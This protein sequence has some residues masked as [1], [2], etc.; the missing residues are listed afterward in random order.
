MVTLLRSGRVAIEETTVA[1]GGFRFRARAA[2]PPDGELVMLLHGFPQSSACWTEALETLASAGYRAVAPDQR[3]YSPGARP[4]G[5]EGYRMSALVADAVRIAEA[6]G[7]RRF[8]V[9]GHDW[10]ATVAWSLAATRPERLAS[11][12]ALSTPHTAAIALALR[13]PVQRAKFAYMWLL[14]TPWIGE[15]SLTL[16]GGTA[17][18]FVMEQALVASG[19][20]R[21]LA[22]R[23]LDALLEVGVTGPLNWYR[24]LRL[25]GERVP[26]DEVS[27]PTMFVWGSRDVAMSRQAAE[28]TEEFVTGEYHFVDLEGANHWIPDLHWDDIAD[29]VLEHIAGG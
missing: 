8:H 20:P 21:D 11:L 22:R 1:A 18:R 25:R 26:V 24:A 29:L 7:H 19:L 27:V 28:A 4:E 9:V 3:G 14:Q 17:G 5:V 23:D 10:G 13:G 2:G 12:T 6:L 15:M 16:G